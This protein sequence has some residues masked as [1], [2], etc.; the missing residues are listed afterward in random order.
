M[1]ANGAAPNAPAPTLPQMGQGHQ[2]QAGARGEAS[3]PATWRCAR[4]GRGGG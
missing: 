3:R 4:H 2:P 1:G